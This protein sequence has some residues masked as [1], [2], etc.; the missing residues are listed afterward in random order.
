MVSAAMTGFLYRFC[1][2]LLAGIGMWV[3]SHH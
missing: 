3:I 2:V 1:L